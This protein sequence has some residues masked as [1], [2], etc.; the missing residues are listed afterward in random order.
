MKRVFTDDE[1]AAL[2][3]E[4]TMRADD[5]PDDYVPD[6][7]KNSYVGVDLPEAPIETVEEVSTTLVDV[8]DADE[9]EDETPPTY[10][11]LVEQAEETL[12]EP[13]IEEAPD[14]P[15]DSPE[16]LSLF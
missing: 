14:E 3:L 5:M 15:D 12:E 11:E 16:Q 9:L 6:E 4:A 8:A 2:R 7:V 10:D 1:L 13:E